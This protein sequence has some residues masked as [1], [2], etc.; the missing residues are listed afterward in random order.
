[1]LKQAV[2]EA[3]RKNVEGIKTGKSDWSRIADCFVLFLV[4]NP[5]TKTFEDFVNFIEIDAPEWLSE[6]TA[7]DLFFGITDDEK[8]IKDWVNENEIEIFKEF[9]SKC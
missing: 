2:L 4:E 8:F 5:N 7:W 1:M 9:L 6:N 3:L